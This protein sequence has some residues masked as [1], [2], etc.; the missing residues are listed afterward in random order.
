[1]EAWEEAWSTKHDKMEAWKRRLKKQQLEHRS[2]R[3]AHTGVSGMKTPESPAHLRT[4]PQ[5][6][7]EDSQ[8][9]PPETDRRPIRIFGPDRTLRTTTPES[10]T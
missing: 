5:I 8:K 1:M 7:L 10:P 9:A 6:K 2:L 4:D 3:P